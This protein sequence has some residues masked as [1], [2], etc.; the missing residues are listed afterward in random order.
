MPFSPH[1][2]FT[3]Y[4]INGIGKVDTPITIRSFLIL[5]HL[6]LNDRHWY[7]NNG[8]KSEQSIYQIDAIDSRP[9]QTEFQFVN[10]KVH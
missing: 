3:K 6:I 8:I 4:T 5:E 10:V 2:A 1:L 9:N 7:L